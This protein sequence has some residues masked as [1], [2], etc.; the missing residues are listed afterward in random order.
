[1]REHPSTNATLKSALRAPRKMVRRIC[2]KQTD[3]KCLIGNQT[4]NSIASPFKT[5]DT[6]LIH[7]TRWEVNIEEHQLFFDP[8]IS[9]RLRPC[10]TSFQEVF[11]VKDRRLP[12]GVRQCLQER[13]ASSGG[14]SGGKI[15]LK[16]MYTGVCIYI[17]RIRLIPNIPNSPYFSRWFV[18]WWR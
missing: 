18:D 3:L 7:K 8:W 13:A 17:Y 16:H 10:S 12:D 2:E 5:Y 15:A 9:P 6:R 4:Q 11:G 14:G 1:M